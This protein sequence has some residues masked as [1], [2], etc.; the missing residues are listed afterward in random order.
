MA[1]QVARTHSG[2]TLGAYYARGL[3]PGLLFRLDNG[4]GP[5]NT[6]VALVSVD[7]KTGCYYCL[8]R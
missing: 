6:T 5:G 7:E 8:R 1:I 3:A 2:P 4:N